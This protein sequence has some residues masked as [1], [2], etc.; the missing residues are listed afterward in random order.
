MCFTR[1]KLLGLQVRGQ[2]LSSDAQRTALRRR[3]EEP[4][5]IEVLQQ[6]TG[7][8]DIKRLGLIK[9][10]QVS[11]VEEVS[12][13]LCVGRRQSGLTKATPSMSASQQSGP[14]SCD[15]HTLRSSVLSA[16]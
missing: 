10:N 6:R 12:V 1:W 11:Q 3:G 4:G 2:H 15:F 7:S 9:E 8:L 16:A 5:Y 14:V 13:F